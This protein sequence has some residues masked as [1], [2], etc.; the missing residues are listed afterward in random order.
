MRMI[1]LT[2]T[3]C[4]LIKGYWPM[5]ALRTTITYP[6]SS[7]TICTFRYQ[8]TVALGMSPTRNILNTQ[9]Y[10]YIVQMSI[11]ANTTCTLNKRE[12]KDS[13]HL[14]FAVLPTDTARKMY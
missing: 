8:F 11:C 2:I 4:L 12:E 10:K 6:L 3:F 14:G 1:I 13:I 5:H 9:F 7:I